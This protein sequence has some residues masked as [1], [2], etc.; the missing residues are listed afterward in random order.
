MKNLSL[1]LWGS[2]TVICLLAGCSKTNN[3][4]SL[5]DNALN[6]QNSSSNPNQTLNPNLAAQD[7]PSPEAMGTTMEN[8]PPIR[9][10]IAPAPCA[11]GGVRYGQYCLYLG[12]GGQSCNE[13]CYYRGG[14]NA[15]TA[16]FSGSN[17]GA[18]HCVWALYYIAVYTNYANNSFSWPASIK[19]LGAKSGMGCT[20][21]K[22]GYSTY[23][24]YESIPVT[25]A[26]KGYGYAGYSNRRVCACNL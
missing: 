6:A 15:A 13:A 26:A 20:L 2:L 23:M 19:D 7:L 16:Y 22:M 4:G 24:T 9:E 21:N 10:A 1:A 18:Y 5:V 25:A 3:G 17:N 12:E 14:Y 8:Q 11:A